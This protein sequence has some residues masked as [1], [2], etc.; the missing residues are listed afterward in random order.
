MKILIVGNGIAGLSAAASL[1]S[2]GEEVVMISPFPSERA[3]SVMAAGGI[4]AADETTEDTVACHIE[5]TLK[6]GRYIAGKDAVTG[7]CE[8]APEIITELERA[9]TV[10]ARDKNG[11]VMRRAFGGQSFN[12]TCFGGTSTGKQIVTALRNRVRRYEAEGK[13][14]MRLGADFHSALIDNGRCYGALV[15]DERTYGLM[16]IYADATIIATGGQ[17]AL[18]GKTT[19]ATTSDGYTAGRLFMQGAVIKN[20]EFIQFHPTTFV[21]P[22][23]NM[24]ISEAARGEGGRLFYEKEGKRIYFMEDIYGEGGNLMPRDVVS[25]EIHK[26]GEEVFLDVSFLGEKKI[27]ERMSETME[28]CMKYGGIDITKEGIPV[29]P[30]VHFFMGGLAVDND[31]MTNIDGLYAAGEC[32]SIY[33]GANRLGGNSMLAAFYGGRKAA[34]AIIEREEIRTAPDLGGFIKEQEGTFY[35]MLGSE[36]KT[37]VTEIR[38]ILASEMKH[39]MGIIRNEADLKSGISSVEGLI[40]RTRN[41]S[42]DPSILPYFNYST[43][44]ILVLAKV[45]MI[46]ALSR[47]E[48]RG[49]HQREEYKEESEEYRCST[50]ITYNSG[51]YDVSYDREGR[52]EH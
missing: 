11:K 44:A 24:L 15:F 4:N 14:E 13:V 47:K 31:H 5:D 20:P 50:L 2:R 45:S 17:N 49:A 36:S 25:R 27:R 6:G 35:K 34:D 10:F 51:S 16:P 32:A 40:D 7:L 23:K 39:S 18:Y 42:F 29:T 8:A 48:S 46:A 41:E 26:T 1:A 12:R 28:L 38:E 19:G 30:S 37:P 9:G 3:Q 21:T 22:Q 43:E 52:Y 33:H